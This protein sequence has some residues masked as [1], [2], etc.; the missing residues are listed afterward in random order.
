[1]L[2]CSFSVSKRHTNS[3]NPS[4]RPWQSRASSGIARRRSHCQA[5][6]SQAQDQEGQACQLPKTEEEA[7]VDVIVTLRA[8]FT[9][10]VI[11]LQQ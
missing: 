7:L 5:N 1:M 6:V 9:F 11:V 4:W 10:R 3:T 2:H 8:A